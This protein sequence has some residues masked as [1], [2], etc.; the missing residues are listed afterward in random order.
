MAEEAAL[1]QRSMASKRDAMATPEKPLVNP[2]PQIQ[3]M[4]KKVRAASPEIPP[5][6]PREDA[7]SDSVRADLLE[8][9]QAMGLSPSPTKCVDE[10]PYVSM[11][12]EMTPAKIVSGTYI[13]M[14]MCVCDVSGCACVLTYI[15]IYVY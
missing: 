13:K 6:Q 5:S 12:M 4:T 1:A 14:C 9:L 10:D 15:Y 7:D 2:S 3:Q 8:R 11:G